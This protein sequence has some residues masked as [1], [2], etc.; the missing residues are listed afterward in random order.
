MKGK[1]KRF[2]LALFWSIVQSRASSFLDMT[3]GLGVYHHALPAAF[4]ADE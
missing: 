1:E 3:S 2:E 4:N